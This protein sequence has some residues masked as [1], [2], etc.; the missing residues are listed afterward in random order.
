LKTLISKRFGVTRPILNGCVS[1]NCANRAVIAISGDGINDALA[2]AGA[3][4]GIDT[5]VA[6]ASAGTTR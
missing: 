1:S 6:M 3:E 4:V 2:R 5:D